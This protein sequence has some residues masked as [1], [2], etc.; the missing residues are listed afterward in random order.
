MSRPAGSALMPAFF[1]MLRAFGLQN[2]L[3]GLA[4]AYSSFTLLSP[5]AS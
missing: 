4:V 2:T 1:L 3:T 5:S